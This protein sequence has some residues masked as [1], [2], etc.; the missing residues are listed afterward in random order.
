MEQ[1]NRPYNYLNSLNSYSNREVGITHPDNMSYVRLTDKGVVEIVA[2]PGLA[3]LMNPINKSITLIADDIRMITNDKNGLKWNDLSFNS[4]GT[5]STEPTF[6]QLEAS[7]FKG[8]Y[9]G[10]DDYLKD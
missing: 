1:V 9:E 5:S 2:C 4:K 3:I 7:D 10:F 8:I 6:M